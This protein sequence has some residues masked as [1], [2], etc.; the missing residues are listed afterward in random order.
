MGYLPGA[1]QDACTVFQKWL[2]WF[3]TQ[4]K[5][6]AGAEW[7][8]LRQVPVFQEAFLTIENQLAQVKAT[9]VLTFPFS[10]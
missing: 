9:V 10:F 8:G 7:G 1:S 3:T 2:Q 6:E 5:E 4:S